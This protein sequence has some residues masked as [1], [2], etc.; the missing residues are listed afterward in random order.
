MVSFGTFSH[1]KRLAK[2]L[3][4][5]PLEPEALEALKAAINDNHR[6]R[7]LPTDLLYKLYRQAEKAMTEVSEKS[8]LWWTLYHI[9]RSSVG[10]YE[11][12]FRAR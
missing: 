2:A 4:Q 10:E 6:F 8:P 12:R 1:E 11:N 3:R 7:E 9:F 5:R